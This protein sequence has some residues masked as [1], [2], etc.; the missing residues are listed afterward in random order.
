MK[1]SEFEIIPHFAA[2]GEPIK[3]K[4][5]LTV[6]SGDEVYGLRIWAKYPGVG[7]IPYYSDNSFRLAAGKPVELELDSTVPDWNNYLPMLKTDRFV[8]TE[9]MGV[10][11]GNSGTRVNLNYAF[12]LLDQKYEPVIGKLL[13]IRHTNGNEDDEGEQVEVKFSIATKTQPKFS[14][15]KLLLYYQQDGN[16][17]NDTPYLD[18]SKYIQPWIESGEVTIDLTE[19]LKDLKFDKNSDWMFRME[20]GDQFE[21]ASKD[22]EAPMA[23]ANLHLSGNPKGGVAFGG[24]HK[25][26][27]DA[28]G[29]YVP[30]LDSHYLIR[31]FAGI[32]GVTNYVLGEEDTGGKWIYGEPIYRFV[33]VGKTAILNAENVIATLPAD[34]DVM[35]T[36]RAMIKTSTGSWR[37]VPYSYYGSLNWSSTLYQKGKDIYLSLGSAHT[38]EKEYI[39]IAEYTKK[40][41]E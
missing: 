11:L 22:A 35:I 19:Y 28:K 10:Q 7:D 4:L 6:E 5:T 37:P 33:A 41:E 24:F 29:K 23:F 1:V 26:L 16:I 40:E 9:Y 21:L 38:A 27:Y 12:T 2:T 36:L 20:F 15:L 18:F 39:I 34:P 8:Q 3:I 13:P 14:V 30:T 17:T 25:E 31:P 32:A